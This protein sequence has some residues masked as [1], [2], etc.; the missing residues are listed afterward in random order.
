MSLFMRKY[1]SFKPLGRHKMSRFMRKL[2]FIFFA[3]N[4]ISNQLANLSILVN[5]FDLCCLTPVSVSKISS[6]QIS[7][8]LSRLVY[9]SPGPDVIKL[10]S[11]STQLS[12][13]FK[14]L[15]N[16]EMAKVK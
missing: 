2:T 15:I 1:F 7:L 14:L 9:V 3:N 13:K 6:M 16:I 11:C 12:M 8:K 5:V 4:K 10:F